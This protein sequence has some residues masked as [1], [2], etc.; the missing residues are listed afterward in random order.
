M[1]FTRATNDD[2]AFE[3]LE[4]NQDQAY[5]VLIDG[6]DHLTFLECVEDFAT[7]NGLIDGEQE[8]SDQFDAMIDEMLEGM[9]YREGKRL[10]EDTDAMSEMFS[11]WM[12]CQL[13]DGQ[14][15]QEQIDN[16]DYIGEYE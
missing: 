1:N 7:N 8:A 2:I 9:S 14:L 12:D 11:N 3:W 16:Y 6:Y 13:S 15:H 5:E 4:N 10:V